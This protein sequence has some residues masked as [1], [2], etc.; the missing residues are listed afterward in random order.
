MAGRAR[1]CGCAC[2]AAVLGVVLVAG[3]LWA[4][5]TRKGPSKL[6]LAAAEFQLKQFERQVAGAGGRPLKLSAAGKEALTRIA[7]LMKEHRGHAKVQELFQRAK[8]TLRASKGQ[9]LEITD[10][11]LAYR[12]REKKITEAI[13]RLN[14]AEFE[15]LR[16]TIAA[17]AGT[18][19]TPF[20]APSPETV[21]A[22]DVV[23]RHV[24]LEGVE[25]PTHL[26][27]NAG[28]SYLF[29]GSPTK[30]F[31]YIHASNRSFAGAYEAIK[32]FRRRV[33]QDVPARWTV[34]GRILRPRI[35]VP[36]AGKTKMMDARAGWVV[37]PIALYAAGRVLALPDEQSQLGGRFIGEERVHKMLQESWTVR[38]IP[39]DAKPGDVV[40]AMVTA[41]KEKNYPLYCQAIDPSHQETTIQK[42]LMLYYWDIFQE[43]LD[44]EYVH[45]QIFKVG[46]PAVIQGQ[47][48]E[49]SVEEMFLDEDFK[50]KMAKHALPLIEEVTLWV[51][52][53]DENGR[54]FAGPRPVTLRRSAEHENK[55][56]W[57]VYRGYPF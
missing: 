22:T 41:V 23:G 8:K 53:Y 5:A 37:S 44:Q 1:L 52:R 56:R 24:I 35:M 20:P 43:D 55:K 34:I 50:N 4:G 47:V 32:R 48:V 28:L 18:I 36:E 33:T 2:W 9:M 26:F 19:V 16:K 25:Y 31:Y 6:K 21:H 49:H 57:Y 11:M 46:Q 14:V 7:A 30:G 13:A 17:M 12:S 54:M 40:T 10:E 42:A 45:A 38:S 3:P 51:R 29:C 27:K 39:N 15:T